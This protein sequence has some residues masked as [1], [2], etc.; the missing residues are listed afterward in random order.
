M[1]SLERI[2][3]PAL[4]LDEEKVKSNIGKMK[5]ISERWGTELRPHFKTH[6]SLQ[7][8]RWFR[9][10]GISRITV[11]SLRM[12]TYFRKDGWRDITLAFPVNLREIEEINGLSKSTDLHLIVSDL[13]TIEHLNKSLQRK[14]RVFIEVDAG[15]DRSGIL[16]SGLDSIDRAVEAVVQ[17]PVMDF[18]GFLTHAGNTYQSRDRKSIVS[19]SEETKERMLSLGRKYSAY[20]PVIT[21]GDTP[22]CCVASQKGYD[23]VRPGNAVFFDLM[24]SVIG[25][26]SLSEIAVAM[27]CPV[28]SV[29]R[30]RSKMVLYGGAVHLSKDFVLRPDGSR[31]YGRLLRF[32]A[33]GW[34]VVEPEAHVYSLSQEHGLIRLPQPEIPQWK[35]GDLA[36]IL[37]VHSCLTAQQMRSYTGLN[38]NII[39]HMEG[40]F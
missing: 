12:A 4:L 23:E 22:S 3:T 20:N 6:Q 13:F 14:L 40:C 9:E 5:A 16:H 11:S 19:V 36:G 10:S 8:G 25:S 18:A 35:P 28:V 26:C 38:G 7:V 37:P 21:T 24:Q 34:Q 30:A 17:S 29:D 1:K 32:T 31:S 39:D 2:K 15:Y 27:A 33:G